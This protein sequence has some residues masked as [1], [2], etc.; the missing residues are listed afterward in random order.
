MILSHAIAALLLGAV[1]RSANSM[2]PITTDTVAPASSSAAAVRRLAA[3]AQLAAQEYALGVVDGRVVLPAEVEEA[4]LFLEE[5]KR[6]AG[7]LPPEWSGAAIK[8]IDA[9]LLLVERRAAPTEVASRVRRLTTTLSTALGV[10]LD[11]VPGMSP[12]LARGAELY[13]AQCAQCHGSLGRGDGPAA[14]GLDPVPA[15]LTDAAGLATQSPLDFYRRITI[16][17]VGTA[18]PSYEATLSAEDRWAVAS[19]AS[20]LRLPAAQG[21]VPAS[22]TA[23]GTTARLSDSALGDALAASANGASVL[24]RV[25]AVRSYQPAQ[26][27]AAAVATFAQVRTQIDET[28]ALASERRPDDASARAFDAYMTFEGVERDVRAKNPSLATTLEGSFATLRSLAAGGAPA[29]ELA[30]A[31]TTLLGQLENAER[32]LG[33]TLSATSLFIQSFFLLVREGLEA[34]LIIGALLTFLAKTGASDRKRDI[35]VGVGAAVLAS[36]FTAV[37]L[38]TVFQ[39]TPAR[40]EVLE[41][42]VMLSASAVLF[43]VSYWLLSKIEVARWNQFVRSRVQDAVTSGSALALATAAFLAVYREGFETVLFYKA[44]VLAGPSGNTFVPVVAGIALGSLVLVAVY[45]AIN[46][47]GVRLPLKPFFAVT[48]LFLYYM[49]FLFAGRG[50]A[51]LQEGG[52]VATTVLPWAPRIPALGIYPTVESLLA[53]GVLVALLLGAIMWSFLSAPRRVPEAPVAIEPEPPAV[54]ESLVDPAVV[55][56][57]RPIAPGTRQGLVRSL[58]R[59][60]GDLAELRSEVERMREQLRKDQGASASR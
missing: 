31:R 24:A 27:G 41:G 25:A 36:L 57:H 51:E 45:Y 2:L 23:F 34:I 4:R 11:D 58:E 18:M 44:L 55:E 39:V 10:S 37:L 22:L 53:Q 46:R 15:N 48:G 43:Y 29:A 32:T 60:E 14:A 20:L 54:A 35:H 40:R 33:D 50:I 59:M 47:F 8:E 7:Q 3:T 9:V 56:G 21:D 52:V 13:Q 6:S 30:L 19:Y 5:S 1:P 38:E 16:G 17:V 49:A 26:Q 28:L 12:S 42:A